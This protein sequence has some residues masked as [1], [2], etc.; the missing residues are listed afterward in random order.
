MDG[1][2]QAIFGE[3]F[4]LFLLILSLATYYL[5]CFGP[6]SAFVG[7]RALSLWSENGPKLEN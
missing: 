7:K 4:A 3:I 2:G 5:E 1:R 6:K